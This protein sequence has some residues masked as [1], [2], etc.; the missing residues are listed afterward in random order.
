MQS[1]DRVG[2]MLAF[3]GC[4]AGCL[5]V[6][7]GAPGARQGL[8]LSIADGERLTSLVMMLGIHAPT[9]IVVGSWV[10]R[11]SGP[12]LFLGTVAGAFLLAVGLLAF[13]LPFLLRFLPVYPWGAN[14]RWSC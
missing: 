12:R 10:S 5:A 6:I 9:L 7:L 8:G 11:A 14:R 2:P 13:S 4:L 3:L 1:D